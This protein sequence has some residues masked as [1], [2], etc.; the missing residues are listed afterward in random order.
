MSSS[1]L[2]PFKH[3]SAALVRIECGINYPQHRHMS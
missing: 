1:L 2:N 3:K